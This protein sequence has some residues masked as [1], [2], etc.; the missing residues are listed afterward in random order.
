VLAAGTLLALAVRSTADGKLEIQLSGNYTMRPDGAIL[1]GTSSTNNKLKLDYFYTPDAGTNP[2]VYQISLAADPTVWSKF[3]FVP[4][5]NNSV[6]DGSVA[7]FTDQVGTTKYN[8]A[9]VLG[10][11]STPTPSDGSQQHLGTATLTYSPTTSFNTSVQLVDK[12]S[13][14]DLTDLHPQFLD[15]DNNPLPVDTGNGF[16]IGC[17]P[18]PSSLLVLLGGVVPMLG[19]LRRRMCDGRGYGERL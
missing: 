19:M 7:R 10:L 1:L 3:T 18:G 6:F 9:L 12:N 11:S 17:A 16:K 5:P 2:K 13:F 15:V 8:N 14:P 4:D